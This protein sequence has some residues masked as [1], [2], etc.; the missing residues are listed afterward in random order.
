MAKRWLRGV[1]INTPGT[2]QNGVDHT[3]SLMLIYHFLVKLCGFTHLD[4][5]VT[6]GPTRTFQTERAR[7]DEHRR[8]AGR[9]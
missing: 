7:G 4:E 1:S 8:R 2:T 9:D 6:G 3:P 5:V